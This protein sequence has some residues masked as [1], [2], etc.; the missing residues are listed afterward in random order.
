MEET[1]H[2][3]FFFTEV[4]SYTKLWNFTQVLG[5]SRYCHAANQDN[6]TDKKAYLSR[7]RFFFQTSNYDLVLQNTGEFRNR[8]F[9]VVENEY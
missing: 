2:P 7:A 5:K 9:P 8:T 3:S 4:F 1:K 6:S